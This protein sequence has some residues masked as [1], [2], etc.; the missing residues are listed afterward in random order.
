MEHPSV[1]QLT[2]YVRG[3]SPAQVALQV[4]R[5]VGSCS[6]C[7]SLIQQLRGAEADDS[8]LY[9][10]LADDSAKYLGCVTFDELVAFIDGTLDDIDRSLVE[11]HIQ[12]C[13]S[14]SEDLRSLIAFKESLLAEER[15]SNQAPVELSRN[16]VSNLAGRLATVRLLPAFG[17]GLAAVVLLV[18]LYAQYRTM[19]RINLQ[20][21]RGATYTKTLEQRLAEIEEQIELRVQQRLSGTEQR[22]ASS[23]PPKESLQDLERRVAAVEQRT[24]QLEENARLADTRPKGQGLR[25]EQDP[26]AE[27]KLL[28]QDTGG[29]VVVTSDGRIVARH[30]TELPEN[31]RQKVKE[32]IIH[33][34]AAP[35]RTLPS[36][37]AVVPGQ[38]NLRSA[39]DPS[40]EP[41]GIMPL[42][43]PTVVLHSPVATGTKTSR[44]VFRWSCDMAAKFRI[45]VTRADTSEQVWEAG[46][47]TETTIVF[48][49]ELQRGKVYLWQVEADSRRPGISNVGW[50]WVMD[51]RSLGEVL[52]IERSFGHSALTLAAVYEAYGLYDDAE[53]QLAKLLQLNPNN[54]EVLTMVEKVREH[55]Q[56]R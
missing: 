12:E 31:I 53:E 40:S 9:K 16:I 33:G 29:Q 10:V 52:Q 54:H 55:R 7:R 21:Q 3:L 46:T 36:A 41:H 42:P 15:T 1:Q 19:E 18:V 2:D 22:V 56:G 30:L 17:Y 6:Q 5:H 23:G 38:A 28:V 24:Q 11:S 8:L 20:L 4:D 35:V 27:V 50:F 26:L 48:P 43:R 13:A 34:K 32:L 39:R 51:E 25:Q 14:C 37:L 45:V 47:G 49:G 44:P